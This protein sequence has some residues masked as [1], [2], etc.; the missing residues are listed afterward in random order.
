MNGLTKPTS[1]D[2][3]RLLL[4]ADDDGEV[5]ADQERRALA[6]EIS[7]QAAG[8]QIRCERQ[9]SFPPRSEAD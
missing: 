7:L 4:R 3:L 5:V 1:D 6:D 2:K 9:A 8:I